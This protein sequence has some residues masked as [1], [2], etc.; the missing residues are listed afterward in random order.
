MSAQLQSQSK[1]QSEH[2]RPHEQL[3]VQ[4]SKGETAAFNDMERYTRQS[5]ITF[6]DVTRL[7]DVIQKAFPGLSEDHM[8][9]G[10]VCRVVSRNFKQ[11]R[12]RVLRDATVWIARYLALE[13]NSE[14]ADVRE[15]KEL[16]DHLTENLTDHWLPEV[17]VFASKHILFKKISHMGLIFLRC[18][19]R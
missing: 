3:Y 15:F 11:W 10:E 5:L 17:F 9:W 12:N 2:T 4:Y 13:E 8:I 14:I 6:F 1:P 7:N 18:K 16:K 19:L